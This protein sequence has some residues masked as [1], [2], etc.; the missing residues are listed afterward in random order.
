MAASAAGLL[1]ALSVL[2]QV[3]MTAPVTPQGGP[4]VPVAIV[5]VVLSEPSA[6][7]VTRWL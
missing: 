4:M 2:G 5:Q 3:V 1:P 7:V 6:P